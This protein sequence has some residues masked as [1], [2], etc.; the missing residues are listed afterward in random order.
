M[1]FSV[2]FQNAKLIRPPLDLSVRGN[3]L[4]LTDLLKIQQQ[5][6]FVKSARCKARKN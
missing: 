4:K 5:D 3:S 1:R 2:S 6:G